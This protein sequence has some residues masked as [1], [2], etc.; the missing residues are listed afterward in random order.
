MRPAQVLVDSMED[1]GAAREEA[2]KHVPA[3]LRLDVCFVPSHGA[4][5]GLMGV[6]GQ[7]CLA[8]IGS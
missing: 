2:S 3:F 4:F 6:D 7:K 8:S 5:Q 1:H